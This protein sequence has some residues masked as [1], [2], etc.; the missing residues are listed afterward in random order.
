MYRIT[1]A[2]TQARDTWSDVRKSNETDTVKYSRIESNIWL[3]E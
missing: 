3:S 1:A 2:T